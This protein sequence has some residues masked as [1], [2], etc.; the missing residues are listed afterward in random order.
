MERAETRLEFRENIIYF[1]LVVKLL[2]NFFLENFIL[3]IGGIE[4]GL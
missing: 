1:Q 2:K 4:I 3:I